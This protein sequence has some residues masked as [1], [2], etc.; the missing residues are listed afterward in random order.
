M[1]SYIA[2]DLFKSKPI[3]RD[4]KIHH[5]VMQLGYSSPDGPEFYTLHPEFIINEEGG[6]LKEL[7]DH[8]RYIQIRK[9]EIAEYQKVRQIN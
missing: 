9:K 5:I 6:I 7:T 4:G 1:T 8:S 3:K 2:G